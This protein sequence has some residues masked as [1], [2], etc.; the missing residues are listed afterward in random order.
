M[1]AHSSVTSLNSYAALRLEK[2]NFH[3]LFEDVK[4][5]KEKPQLIRKER[6]Q[7]INPPKEDMVNN[8]ERPYK[9]NCFL[10]GNVKSQPVQFL[11]NTTD[12]FI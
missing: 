5:P 9:A 12:L 2:G 11:I 7:P 4:A 8:L 10:L 6:K 1:Q 3:S